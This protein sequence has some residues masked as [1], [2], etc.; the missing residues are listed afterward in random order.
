MHPTAMWTHR[1]CKQI[2]HVIKKSWQFYTIYNEVV[3]WQCSSSQSVRHK[4]TSPTINFV[5]SIPSVAFFYVTY[6]YYCEEITL[7]LILTPPTLS[8]WSPSFSKSIRCPL[9]D[10]V[11]MISSEWSWDTWQGKTMLSPT[12]T[13]MLK[14]DTITRVG[15]TNNKENRAGGG[16]TLILS[17]WEMERHVE[18]KKILSSLAQ[19]QHCHQN[20]IICSDRLGSSLMQQVNYHIFDFILRSLSLFVGLKH[21]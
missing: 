18:L 5:K 7:V 8:K 13:S 11:N 9:N 21:C 19:L 20:L 16:E 2:C 6:F 4:I 10:Q 17:S 14:G 3:Y 12:V 15:S 1:S